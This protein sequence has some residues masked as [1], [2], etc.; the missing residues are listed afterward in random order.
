MRWSALWSAE[1]VAELFDVWVE[2]EGIGF[3]LTL[4]H[5]GGIDPSVM[6]TVADLAADLAQARHEEKPLATALVVGD[7]ERVRAAVS[8]AEIRLLRLAPV[9]EMRHTIT[10]LASLVDGRVLAYLVDPHGVL[11]DI[12]KVSGLEPVPNAGLLGEQFCRYLRLTEVTG[13]VA[14]CLPAGGRRV[15]VLAAGTI[16][17]AF[18]QGDWRVETLPDLDEIATHLVHDEGYDPELLERILNCAFRMS[19]QNLGAIFMIGDADAILLRS[20]P[21]P[22]VGD[23]TVATAHVADLTDDE[24]INFARQDGATIID[25]RGEFR[26]CMIMLR[27]QPNTPAEIELGRGTRHATAAKMSAETHALAITVSQDG[28]ITVYDGGRKVLRL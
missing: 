19:A 14:F 18:E 24:L 10:S 25:V 1:T 11:T 21:L 4:A 5:S 13:A 2:E 22:I 6:I 12:I 7:P 15:K 9:R 26:G 27:P 17:G 3:L 16:V 8:P 28:P 20:D 23:I